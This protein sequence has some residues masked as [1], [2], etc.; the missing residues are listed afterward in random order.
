MCMSNVLQSTSGPQNKDQVLLD[1]ILRPLTILLSLHMTA[2]A[3]K[4][5]TYY[6]YGGERKLFT[7]IINRSSMHQWSKQVTL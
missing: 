3:N 7:S 2:S 5:A 1:D 4:K 6:R